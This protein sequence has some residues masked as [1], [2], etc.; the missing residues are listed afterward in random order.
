[1][2]GIFNLLST[3]IPRHFAYTQFCLSLQP[4]KA[5]L[6]TCRL[7]TS[8]KSFYIAPTCDIRL[9]FCNN[10]W[11]Q[12][13]EKKLIVRYESLQ[14][15]KFFWRK[16]AYLILSTRSLH[17]SFISK[18]HLFSIEMDGSYSLRVACFNVIKSV[19]DERAATFEIHVLD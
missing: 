15:G 13:K 4:Q 6:N 19:V 7:N 16:F 11:F 5:E 2:I 18:Y 17:P 1:M 9:L 10:C 3:K 8:L 14:N 12:E